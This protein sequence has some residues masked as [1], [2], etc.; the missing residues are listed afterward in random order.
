MQMHEITE[1]KEATNVRDANRLLQEGWHFVA[2]VPRSTVS[3]YVLGRATGPEPKK[4]TDWQKMA[5]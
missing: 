2:V 1:L 3:V 4:P 5:G